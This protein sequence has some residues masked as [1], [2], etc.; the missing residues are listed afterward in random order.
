MKIFDFNI[1]LP[2]LNNESVDLKIGNER[3][4][5]V[6]GVLGAIDYYKVEMNHL[7]GG[8]FML[9]NEKLLDE[10][11]RIGEITK[12]FRKPSLLSLLFDFRQKDALDNVGVAFNSGIRALKFHS[13]VQKIEESDFHLIVEV[14]KKASGLGMSILIDASFG[15]INMYK[16]DNLKL[17]CS[18]L[19]EVKKT[20]VVILHSGGAR[21]LEAMLI[22]E[23]M[24][25]VFLETSFSLPYYAGSSIES[26]LAFV[27]KKLG[28]ERL[29]YGSDFPYVSF[30]ESE[31]VHIDFF[32][33]YNFSIH[34]VEN[35]MYNNAMK[36]IGS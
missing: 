14:S 16:Y 23:E 12:Q 13:Y 4:L 15:S 18:I 34:E 32:K 5:D 31:R 25:N 9:F 28:S 30:S 24:Q 21:V 7:E 8:N 1:H 17:A 20:P 29:L 35:V 27:Y 36:L 2:I 10:A 22:A 26:D 19:R 3:E 11:N 33:K 6:E